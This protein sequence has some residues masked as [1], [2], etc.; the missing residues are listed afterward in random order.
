MPRDAIDT[1]VHVLDPARFPFDPATA[2]Q[3]QPHEC[4]TA[5][6]LAQLLDAHGIDRVVLV[7]PTSGY[8]LDV[9]CLVDAVRRLGSR[10]RGIARVPLAIDRRRLRAL[11]A[12]GIAGIR[13]DLVADG[14]P[15]QSLEPLLRRLVD[16]DMVLT[17]QCQADQLAAIAPQLGRIP[18]RIVVD[19]LGRPVPERGIDQPGFR[20]LLSLAA[21]GRAAVKVSGAMRCS[22]LEAPHVDI[23]P[24]VA[25]LAQSFGPERLMWA[26]DWPFLRSPARTDYAP[27]LAHLARWFPRAADRR[28]ILVD[29]P[30]RFFGFAD[31]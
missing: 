21:T 16:E 28:R 19:H 7:N 31:R 1:H 18:V 11:A 9:R 14:V 6:A 30:A 17:I 2:Y 4:G 22:R 3:P 29:T 8:G 26:S 15:A 24:F 23:D 5:A 12:R 27:L 25:A 13:L 10:A 20:A